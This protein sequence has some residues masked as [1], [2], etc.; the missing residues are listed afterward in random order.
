MP[1]GHA[2]AL[3]FSGA[4]PNTPGKSKHKN[5]TPLAFR[6]EYA[7]LDWLQHFFYF[8]DEGKYHVHLEKG[9]EYSIFEAYPDKG[10]YGWEYPG[11]ETTRQMFSGAFGTVEKEFFFAPFEHMERELRERFGMDIDEICALP[12]GE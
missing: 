5:W 12:L 2:A 10:E 3:S 4:K 9:E 11:I 7:V 1:A 6:D 8:A